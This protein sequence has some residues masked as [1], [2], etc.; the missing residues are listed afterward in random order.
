MILPTIEHTS[1][2]FIMA[3][4]IDESLCDMMIENIE[5]M[6]KSANYDKARGYSRLNESHLDSDIKDNYIAEASH[7]KTVIHGKWSPI[8]T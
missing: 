4:Q 5:G 2:S 8:Y 3:Y 1:P 6:Q 7:N